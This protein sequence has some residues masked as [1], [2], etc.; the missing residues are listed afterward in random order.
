MKES[1]TTL[2]GLVAGFQDMTTQVLEYLPR[3][4]AA[5]LVLIIGWLLARL[6]RLLLERAVGRL[7][8][9]W[10]RLMSKRGLTHLEPRHPPT[11]IIGVLVFWLVLLIFITLA[12]DILGLDIFGTWMKGNFHLP[13]IGCGRYFH[14]TGWFRDQ[15]PGTRPDGICGSLCRLGSMVIY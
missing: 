7:D 10:Q 14:R 3:V 5:M 11:R 6:L 13:A 15:F 9:F 1:V 12:A 8:Q 2:K 4:A